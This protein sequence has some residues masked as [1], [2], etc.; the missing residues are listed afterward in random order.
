MSIGTTN[1]KH[2][3]KK[4]EQYLNE[5]FVVQDRMYKSSDSLTKVDLYKEYKRLIRKAAY[6]GNAEAQYELGLTYEDIY[7]FGRNPDY[8][9]SKA[10]YWYKKACEGNCAAACNNLASSYDTGLGGE[11][12]PQLALELY[13]KAADLGDI[14]AKKNYKKQILFM[15]KNEG[16]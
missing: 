9:P 2:M 1:T 5:A 4:S 12:D 14:L 15:R 3:Q 16:K 7:I 6:L 10:R 8:N 11:K 13:K